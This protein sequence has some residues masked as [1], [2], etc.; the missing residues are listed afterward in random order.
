MNIGIIGLQRSGKTTIFNSLTG[1]KGQGTGT[2]TKRGYSQGVIDV[3]DRRIDAL[4]DIFRPK[5]I[6]YARIMFS[7]FPGSSKDEKGFSTETMRRLNEVDAIT[8]VIRGYSNGIPARPLDDLGTVFA[9]MLLSDIIL[10]ERS[11]NRLEKER[12]NPALLDVM[13][14]INAHLSQDK[15]LNLMP[16]EAYERQMVAGYAFIT[17]KPVLAVLNMDETT[18]SD[19]TLCEEVEG[20]CKDKGWRFMQI[21][22]SIEEEIARLNPD[23]QRD[24]LNDL[25]VDESARERFIKESFDLMGLISFF[26]VGEDE[27]KAWPL[28]DGTVA[29]KGSSRIHSDI[30]RGFIRAEVIGFDAFMQCRQMQT[31]RKNG[32]LRLEG[33]EYIIKDG[34]II[35]FR[36]NV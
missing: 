13:N 29:S 7:D 32:L 1:L 35:N 18:I 12:R 2:I 26:T 33:K 14:R 5:K 16:L 10:A 24:F 22:G 23:E 19:I 8:L 30:E 15:P 11:I 3:P 28:Y 4:S 20:F 36:F 17:I 6:T 34:D 31:A 9:D 27:V 21:Y 25:G